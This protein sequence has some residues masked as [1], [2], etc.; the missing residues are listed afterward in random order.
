MY[1]Y[2]YIYIQRDVDID[3][4]MYRYRSNCRNKVH[5]YGRLSKLG[6]LFGSPK[7]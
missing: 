2:I 4:D 3:V 1:V 5:I 6:S 7:Y